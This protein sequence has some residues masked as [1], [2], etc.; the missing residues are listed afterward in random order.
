MLVGTLRTNIS[1]SS[2]SSWSDA[3][4]KCSRKRCDQKVSTFT[5]TN[6]LVLSSQLKRLLGTFARGKYKLRLSVVI[7]RGNFANSGQSFY[8]SAHRNNDIFDEVFI[9]W[10]GNLSFIKKKKM[11][12]IC[13]V[14]G[15]RTMAKKASPFFTEVDNSV[16]SDKLRVERWLF[17]GK[18]SCPYMWL[19][20]P[21]LVF[22]NPGPQVK[23]IDT[24][25]D[26]IS[27][28]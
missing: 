18:K 16:I 7:K 3:W 19:K 8:R 13:W 1:M 27:A 5:I 12:L 25:A 21:Y 10:K 17:F 9:V 20:C 26:R 11:L 24:I 14:S 15:R 2:R 22:E 23:D 6:P 4:I 28:F